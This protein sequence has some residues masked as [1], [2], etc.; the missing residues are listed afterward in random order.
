MPVAE[1]LAKDPAAII[2]SGGPA[3]VYEPGAPQIDPALFDAGVPVFGIC[4][5]FQAMAQALGGDGRPHRQP[6]S[7]GAPRCVA[8]AGRGVC[9]PGCRRH[10]VWMSHGDCVTAAPA[11][12][13]VTAE[14]P[15]ARSPRSRT[16]PAGGP[17]CSSTRRWRT[18]RTA[19]RMLR[20]FL[21]DIAGIEP[22]LDPGEHHRR[23]GG[24]DPGP[25]RRRAVI[26]GLSGGVD[27]AVAAALVHRAVGDQL[28]CV[29]VDHGLLRAGEASRWRRT[30]SPR[31]A[32]S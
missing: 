21:H 9:W 14:S 26:C 3:S 15:G 11:G 17:A 32:S 7:S 20:R 28:T 4:Y 10:A 6:A 24:R 2:L 19:R 29:F 1:M 25:G 30:T 13:T 18:P 27:S 31:P 8:G 5:G 12:F 23:A 22:D 16:W